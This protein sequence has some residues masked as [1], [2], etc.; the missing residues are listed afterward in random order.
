MSK[1]SVSPAHI[2]PTAAAAL[3]ILCALVYFTGVIFFRAHFPFHTTFLTYDV[4]EQDPSAINDCMASETEARTL[5]VIDK[6]GNRETID[7][8]SA[9][10]YQRLAAEP[11]GGWICVHDAWSWPLRLRSAAVLPA[12]IEIRYDKGMLQDAVDALA[13]MD[14]ENVTPPRD[15]YL[16]WRDGI[17]VLEPEEDGNELYPDRLMDALMTAIEKDLDTVDL[18]D[19]DFYRT[20]EIRSDDPELNRTLS[21]YQAIRFQR[22][23]I[24]MTGAVVTLT[25]DDILALYSV[26]NA[27]NDPE[28]ILSEKAV[29][30]LVQ[31]LKDDY[32]TYEGQRPFTNHYG[33]EITVGTRADTYGF[34]MDYNATLEVV[35]KALKSKRSQTIQPVWINAGL[36][37]RENGSDIG[38]TYIEVS[39]SEQH[40]WAYQDGVQILDSNVVT[41]NRGD[42][43]TPRGVFRILNK[44]YGATLIGEDYET[45]VN[46]WMPITWSG[47]GLHDA[48]WR[49][50]FGGSIYTY[51]GSHGCVNLPSSV[52][53]ELFNIYPVDTPVVIW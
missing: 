24:D 7:L 26:A 11:E 10:G 40:L 35:L 49:G 12:D 29:E 22:L 53:R 31:K 44:K 13:I 3:L 28:Y 5:T 34:R 52:A 32:D 15:A 9:A 4:S 33:S 16:E 17:L 14:P 19:G 23:E 38:D 37:R 20:A 51:S 30:L 46:Y 1:R 42:H 21:R 43:D 48:Y 6:D 27:P 45:Y 50:S 18:S 39:I 41:G 8:S 25:P 2:L 47:V 36:D